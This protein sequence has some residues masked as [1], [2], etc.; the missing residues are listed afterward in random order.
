V[1]YILRDVVVEDRLGEISLAADFTATPTR[2]FPQSM[3]YSAGIALA[4]DHDDHDL[5][6]TASRT[7]VQS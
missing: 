3:K 6:T 5:T 7:T 1:W 4:F 2:S